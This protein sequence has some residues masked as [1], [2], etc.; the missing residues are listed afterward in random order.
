[1][2]PCVWLLCSI[3]CLWDSPMIL[4]TI[5]DFFCYIL[6]YDTNVTLFVYRIVD[7][8]LGV[9]QFEVI[10]NKVVVRWFVSHTFFVSSESWNIPWVCIQSANWFSGLSNLLLMASSVILN[11]EIIFTVAKK[12]YSSWIILFCKLLF[13]KR[14][15]GSSKLAEERFGAILTFWTFISYNYSL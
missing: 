2:Y 12:Y 11:S 13:L 8:H 5:F 9:F 3:S 10:M 15:N 14:Y 1:M 7:G 4:Q 6:F